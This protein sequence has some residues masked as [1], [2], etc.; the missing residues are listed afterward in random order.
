[1][2][3]DVFYDFNALKFK[4]F[5]C[6]KYKYIF[7]KIKISNTFKNILHSTMKLF[8]EGKDLNSNEDIFISQRI[9]FSASY[10]I[11]ISS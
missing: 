4:I 8:Q 3:I 10:Q 11:V 1:M 6:V 7:R 5:I 2:Y 9:L